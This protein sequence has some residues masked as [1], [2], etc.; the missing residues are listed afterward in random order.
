MMMSARAGV[1]EAAGKLGERSGRRGIDQPA[2]AEAAKPQSPEAVRQWL[3][4]LPQE[5]PPPQRNRAAAEW[6]GGR[7]ASRDPGRE[8]ARG[9]GRARWERRPQRS[10]GGGIPARE[11]WAASRA[12]WL[13]ARADRAAARTDR[14]AAGRGDADGGSAW[15][16]RGRRDGPRTGDPRRGPPGDGRDQRRQQGRSGPADRSPFG[17]PGRDDAIPYRPW[18][19]SGGPAG[20]SRPW[21]AER[22]DPT[23]PGTPP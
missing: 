11:K 9:E 22:T 4:R 23:G 19:A 8:G 14:T 2:P 5:H 3:R 7:D 6:P 12:E 1:R 13:A 16:R 15:R 17:A 20:P 18:F 21:F 10:D